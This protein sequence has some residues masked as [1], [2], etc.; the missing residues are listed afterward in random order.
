LRLR[1]ED[2]RRTPAGIL[3][4]VIKVRATG[5]VALAMV[6]IAAA[7]SSSSSP[8]ASNTTVLGNAAAAATTTTTA[9]A[10]CVARPHAPGQFSQTFEFENVARTYQLYV[11]PAYRGTT[12]VPVVFDFHGFGSNAVQQMVYGNF[13][14]LARRDDFLIVAPDGQDTGA[15]RHFNLTDEKGLQNDITMV[16]SLLDRVEATFCVDRARVYAT[17]MSDGG[18]VS[19]ALACLAPNRFAAFCPVAVQV[20]RTGCAGKYPVAMVAFHGTADPIVTYTNQK[21]TCCGGGT[22]GAVPTT[23]AQWA[24]HDHCNAKFTDAGLGTQVVRRTWTGCEGTSSVVLYSII[25][26]GHTWPGSIPIPRLG[27]TTNQINASD[28]IWAFFAAHPLRR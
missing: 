28:T 1:R 20:Y 3:T 2:R 27:M 24:A 26:G 9:P 15:G 6:L 25:G 19:S 10:T 22:L 14:P 5:F 12:A 13:E 21:V 18:G 17:G 7:C 4:G 11:P 8:R 16:L 23:M